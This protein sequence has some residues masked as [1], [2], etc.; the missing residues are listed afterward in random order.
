[1][2]PG[3]IRVFANRCVF[4]AQHRR[5]PNTPH[6]T[7]D[8]ETFDGGEASIGS[9]LCLGEVTRGVSEQAK[10]ILDFRLDFRF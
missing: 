5:D 10:M 3:G 4:I 9:F 2:A 6:P 1:M 7:G 8:G